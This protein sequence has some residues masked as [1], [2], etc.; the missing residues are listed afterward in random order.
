MDIEELELLQQYKREQQ[1]NAS[2]NKD[3][4][5]AAQLRRSKTQEKRLQTRLFYQ[6]RS[7]NAKKQSL[8][9]VMQQIHQLGLQQAPPL[10]DPMYDPNS[11]SEMAALLAQKSHKELKILELRQKIF[12]KNYE[13]IDQNPSRQTNEEVEKQKEGIMQSNQRMETELSEEVLGGV[14]QDALR[15]KA[16]REL[17]REQL[18]VAQSNILQL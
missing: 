9:E 10:Q 16:I 5:M 8:L 13:R 12:L 15:F 4:M 3:K 11:N 17:L 14:Q 18:A 7:I 1:E 6:N 2:Y